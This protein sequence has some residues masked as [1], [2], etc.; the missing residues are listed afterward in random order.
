MVPEV[1]LDS[2]MDAVLPT[3]SSD[4]FDAV[5][6]Q[7]ASAG[8]IKN[9]GSDKPRWECLPRDPSAAEA[10]E[11]VAFQFLGT[12][13]EKIAEYS[14][15]HTSDVNLRLHVSGQ[16]TPLGI[17][18]N[19]SRPDG[20][21]LVE[22][23]QGGVN[24]ADIVMPME[25]KN[26]YNQQTRADD[27]SK[28]IWS[29][30]HTMRNDPRRRYVHGLTCEDTKARLWFHDRCDV[31]ASEEFD[32]NKDWKYLVRVLLSMMVATRVD[33]GYDPNMQ[34]VVS[35]DENSEPSYD[36]TIH[37]PDNGE[38][39][40]YRTVGILSD[41]GA[42]SMVGRGTR[43]WRVRQLVDGRLLGPE[44][45]LKDVWVHEDRVAE[46]ELLWK[47]RRE[48]AASSRHFL[49]PIDHAFVPLN[50]TTPDILDNTNNTLG[51]PKNLKPTKVQLH[52]KIPVVP[53]SR[54]SR[55]KS[56]RTGTRSGSRDS[57]GH[58]DDIPNSPDEGHRK[59]CHLSQHPRKHY[60][61]V[62]KEIG[63]PVHQ[64]RSFSQVFTAIEG[65]WK[66]L[67]AIHL[68]GYVHRDV[69][70]GN[71]LLVQSPGTS[72]Q[73]GVIMDLEYAKETNDT[74]APHDVK[75]GTAM[76]MATEV[77]FGEHHR[78][79]SLRKSS[80]PLNSRKTLKSLGRSL[81][82]TNQYSEST[83]LPPFRHNP[84]HDMESM[85]WLCIWMMFYL[86]H[87]K[88]SGQTNLYNYH[89]VFGTPYSRRDFMEPETRM[90][91]KCTTHLSLTPAFISTMRIWMGSLGDMY[92]DRYK[93]LDD[94]VNPPNLLHIDHG[95]TKLCYDVGIDALQNLK[96]ASEM[97]PD[98]ATLS[99]KCRGSN[100][101]QSNPSITIPLT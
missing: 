42:D 24:W 63:T 100:T 73:W 99:E 1:S 74:K 18:R 38:T 78:L 51:R 9:L 98:F 90:F 96:E 55:S 52:I 43:V 27:Y 6:N 61:I 67:H 101:I 64:L 65:G 7:L 39:N 40:T 23:T 3:I 48:Q 59:L 56:Q 62:F 21:F 4:L 29:M 20:F 16:T 75:T 71:I 89:A 82:T 88:R 26:K 68:C 12:I 83:L 47:I 44:Y 57:V 86:V 37:N 54:A 2:L 15:L 34:T 81:W 35:N 53:M 5:C 77:A 50:P 46:H 32:V 8:C 72:D 80:G 60:R 10:H 28:V 22:G 33:L 91:E 93:E 69:S 11:S 94:S 84:L 19:T 79:R 58:S 14:E 36:I 92:T 49:T 66:G 95:T 31:V 97:L 13:A 87:P 70:S 45:A 85:W 41:V 17:R 30:H 76:F 25:F